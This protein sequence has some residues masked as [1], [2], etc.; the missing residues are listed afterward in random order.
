MLHIKRL[1]KGLIEEWNDNTGAWF[2]PEVPLPSPEATEDNHHGANEVDAARALLALSRGQSRQVQQTVS[3]DNGTTPISSTFSP[4]LQTLTP[5]SSTSPVLPQDDGSN[6]DSRTIT[7]KPHVVRHGF[8]AINDH[9]SAPKHGYAYAPSFASDEDSEPFNP[10]PEMTDSSSPTLD[11]LALSQRVDS[12]DEA[13]DLDNE[14]DSS[15]ITVKPTRQSL[16]RQ[17]RLAVSTTDTPMSDS[18]TV[19]TPSDTDFYYNN[20]TDE[21]LEQVLQEEDARA[22]EL[23]DFDGSGSSS[24]ESEYSAPP[25]KAPVVPKSTDHDAEGYDEFADDT[26]SPASF[27]DADLEMSDDTD[28]A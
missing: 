7:V 2:R 26:P 15:T 1:P 18:D 14:S 25:M 16:Q 6:S 8:T 27:Y 3:T 13:H 9:P 20:T 28:Q 10:E 12:F 17:A 23:S 19:D 22:D 4:P 24:D 11:S 21:E 5:D